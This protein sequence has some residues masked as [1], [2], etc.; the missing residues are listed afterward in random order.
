M[1]FRRLVSFAALILA[2]S[3]ALA[4]KHFTHDRITRSAFLYLD[5]NPHHLSETSSWYEDLQV[6]QPLMKEVL[7]RAIIEADFRTD[8][9]IKGFGQSPFVGVL[10]G[11]A[12]TPFS[13]LMHFQTEGKPA[14]RWRVSD[15]F[16]YNHSS[17]L[18]NDSQLAIPT[19]RLAAG[20]SPAFGGINP[21]FPNRGI[22]IQPFFEGFAGGESSFREMAHKDG[23]LKNVYF[24]PATTV[25]GTVMRALHASERAPKDHIE[26]WIDTLPLLKAD[27]TQDL[28][29]RQAWRG[30]VTGL[31]RGFDH[32]GLAIHL[33]QD[34]A[35]PHHTQSTV[36]LCH[37]E[38]E[39]YTDALT[40]GYAVNQRD[41]QP[42]D[43]GT[44]YGDMRPNCQ[45]LYRPELVAT[46]LEGT[47]PQAT[48]LDPRQTL[49]IV[50]RM[51]AEAS[52][53]A[54]WSWSQDAS[55]RITTVLPNG[56][57]LSG[58]H[59][60]DVLALPEVRGQITVQYNRAVALS[61]ALFESTARAY[62][63]AHAPSLATRSAK[64]APAA[65]P[66]K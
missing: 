46:L 66:K 26:S 51:R 39:D 58:T 1:G 57:R 32:L 24:P 41:Y 40:C 62:E 48:H 15:G 45:K 56:T 59:C 7:A 6:S 13:S 60:K 47:G 50:D 20:Q 54:Q 29:R 64:R 4:F 14:H 43:K 27:L 37:S 25:A 63:Q 16:A 31:P 10:N 52:Y 9:W 34:M 65:K 44:V 17:R 8:V 42:Y 38:L 23:A 21:A 30:E 28:Y 36:D 53:A 22:P 33:A 18:K 2:P 12:P 5:S 35:M 3:Q 49:Q 11:R 55:G 19:A 61:I